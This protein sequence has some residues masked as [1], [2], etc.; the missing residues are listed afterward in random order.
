M[1]FTAL[2]VDDEPLA[3]E[4]LRL[5]LADDPD[6]PAIHEARNG[7][8]AVEVI[9]SVQP[10]LVFLD[11]QMPEMDGFGVVSEIGAER[12]P[13]VVF[14]TAHD[15]Y[16][17]QA[18][19]VNAVDYLLKPVTAARFHTTLERVK[20]RLG[21]SPGDSS[22]RILALLQSM[23]SSRRYVKRLAVRSA[24]KTLFVEVEDIQWMEAAENYVQ[25]HTASATPLVHMPMHALEKSLD[26]ELFVRVHR[27]II[28]NMR[29]VKEMQPA[30]HGEYVI[31]M[32]NGA[33]VQSGRMYHARLKALAGN[34]I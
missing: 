30:T 25:L 19:E 28:V 33:R 31:T 8:E 34:S 24:S 1:P 9:R 15:R 13:S 16:A 4:G 26:P 7:H 22:R 11:V 6:F 23:T 21:A 12:M 10:H 17:V 27:S 5:L 32:Q 20:L 14:V 2:I 18:F 3:R 29:H